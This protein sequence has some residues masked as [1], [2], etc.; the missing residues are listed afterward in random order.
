MVCVCEC[1]RVCVCVWCGE[2]VC[3]VRERVCV[4]VCECE[5][6]CECVCVCVCVCVCERVCVCVCCVHSVTCV[7]LRVSEWVEECLEEISCGS[8]PGGSGAAPHLYRRTYVHL[9]E[10]RA[11]DVP[12]IH[13]FFI[14]SLTGSRASFSG[15]FGHLEEL[16]HTDTRSLLLLH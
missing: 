4:C 13:C 10:P 6:E 15:T 1:E 14:R 3:G 8:C 11:Q 2:R 12:E 5:C 9:S 16:S 7:S